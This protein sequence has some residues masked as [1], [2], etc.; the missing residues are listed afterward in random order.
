MNKSLA[1]VFCLTKNEYDLIEDF[2]IFYASIFGYENIII[3]DNGSDL[4][5]VE[6]I[7]E[8]YKKKGVI[9]EVDNRSMSDMNTIIYDTIQKYKDETQFI[10]PV[11]TDEFI[12]LLNQDT[13]NIET[14]QTYLEELPENVS[15]VKYGK[16][17]GSLADPNDEGYE[18]NKYTKPVRSIKRF[19]NQDWDKCIARAETFISISMGNHK[20]EVTD[21]ETITSDVLG[22][23]HYHQTG[24]KRDFERCVQ[25]VSGY[26]Q[27][28]VELPIEI[29]ILIA[30]AFIE[31][32]GGHR[33]RKHIEYLK[34]MF[35]VNSFIELLQRPPINEEVETYVKYNNPFY[36]FAEIYKNKE[37][38]KEIKPEYTNYQKHL[39]DLV[40]YQTKDI[41]EN[42]VEITQLIKFFSEEDDVDLDD[43]ETMKALIK[44]L[45][46]ENKRL[47]KL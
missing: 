36:I 46:L 11:D 3:I 18:N 14:V 31:Q 9:I 17:M 43:V 8:T 27:F 41:H 44:H 21:G 29:Q 24:S 40:Y 42:E 23:L 33:V 39:E 15:V 4:K 20:V 35:V 19:Y 45:I 6:S 47:K 1:K 34:R 37:E 38:L 30:P 5:D 13:F 7:Y 26:R 10:I 12:Y 32:V 22:L 28:N 2:I 16:L 25:S